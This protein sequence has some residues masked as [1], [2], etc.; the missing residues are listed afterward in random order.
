MSNNKLVLLHSPFTSLC[1]LVESGRFRR[2]I[3]PYKH[4]L[5]RASSMLLSVHIAVLSSSP[6][7][8]TISPEDWTL[9]VIAIQLVLRYITILEIC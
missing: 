4:T 8:R 5:T 1:I 2:M 6:S 3:V 9:H 7:P